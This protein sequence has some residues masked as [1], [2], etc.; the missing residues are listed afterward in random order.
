VHKCRSLRGLR[1][2]LGF[3]VSSLAASQAHAG[4]GKPRVAVMD[5]TSPGVPA[6]LAA[7]GYGLQSMI[8]TDLAQVST[9]VVVERA[10]LQ[11]VQKELRLSHSKSVDPATA[12]RLGKLAGATHL[13]VGTFAV[14][15]KQMR[16]DGRLVDVANGKVVVAASAEGERDAF[17]ELEKTLVKKFLAAMDLKVTAKERGEVA[18][19]HTTDFEAFRQ[20]AIGVRLS[21]DKKYD[22]AIAAMKTALK[23]D[24]EFRLARVALS[25]YERMAAE[26]RGRADTID[27][28]ALNQRRV[29]RQGEAVERRKV[30][31]KLLTIAQESDPKARLRRAAAAYILSCAFDDFSHGSL[32]YWGLE[33]HFA[34]HRMA[35]SLASRYYADALAL[36]PK[37]SPNVHCL[38]QIG[39]SRPRHMADFEQDFS[40]IMGR[41][42]PSLKYMQRTPEAGRLLHLDVHGEA[43]L[44]DQFQRLG[45]KL[46]PPVDW[47]REMLE[48]RARMWHALLDFGQSSMLLKKAADLPEDGGQR[49]RDPE[50]LRRYADQIENNGKLAS[51]LGPVAA[52]SPLRELVR[53]AAYP[54]RHRVAFAG[55]QLVSPK[56]LVRLQKQL[57]EQP[58]STLTWAREMSDDYVLVGRS[59]VWAVGLKGWTGPR[60]DQRRAEELRYFSQPSKRVRST[61]FVVDGLTKKD[62]TLSCDFGFAKPTDFQP[63]TFGGPAKIDPSL[64]PEIFLVFGARCVDCQSKPDPSTGSWTYGEQPTEAWAL[65]LRRDRAELVKLTL[66]SLHRNMR[67]EDEITPLASQPV[68][69]GD[70]ERASVAMQVQ[71]NRL[72]VTVNG[73]FTAFPVPPE[74]EPGFYGVLLRGPGFAA[75]Q[76]LKSP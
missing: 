70:G 47:Q 71:G 44:V 28:D 57:A 68:G 37:L 72:T 54:E 22:E 76:G 67:D 64:R 4:D 45:M 21:D 16:L 20:Y 27:T 60:R 66:R 49:G 41:L 42:S 9:L 62:M 59:P 56:D 23:K 51:A 40:A 14:V 65:A 73:K 52:D 31:A 53:A 3:L 38:S 43:D 69:L 24:E 6:D 18:K 7:L 33:D 29:E 12:A 46:D 39:P 26:L 17:F 19:I 48:R 36:W 2:A 61:L 63:S 11:E 34:M 5:F 10:R 32:D 35:E 15:A 74:T 1:F 50:L 75:L 13:V 8:T 58:A 30:I 25:E 55:P